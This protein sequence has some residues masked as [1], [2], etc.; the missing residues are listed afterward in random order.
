MQAKRVGSVLLAV[1]AC[2]AALSCTPQSRYRDVPL[3]VDADE[4][5]KRL[6]APHSKEATEKRDPGTEYF[7]PRPSDAYLALP[8]GAP[9]EVWRYRR[10]RETWSYVFH[11]AGETA[12]LV[13][14]G[15]HHPSITY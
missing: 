5:V 2:V 4:V 6:G 8:E 13:D 1:C 9:L 15:Y 7:G 14:K 12:I 10:F 11:A 3:G